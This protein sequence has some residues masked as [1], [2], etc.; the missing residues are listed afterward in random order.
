MKKWHY[1]KWQVTSRRQN[2]RVCVCYSSHW[3]LCSEQ[4][5]HNWLVC[6]CRSVFLCTLQNAYVVLRHRIG[7]QLAANKLKKYIIVDCILQW[8]MAEVGKSNDN[9]GDGLFGINPFSLLFAIILNHI[10]WQA[11]KDTTNNNGNEDNR[12]QT[13]SGS[14]PTVFLF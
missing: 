1:K 5:V 3:R 4:P 7:S 14:L 13:N 6:E 12:N 9:D 8:K 2:H 11:K 10:K